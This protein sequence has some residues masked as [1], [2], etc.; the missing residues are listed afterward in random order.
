MLAPAWPG[1]GG[2][3]R[4]SCISN[5]LIHRKGCIRSVPEGTWDGEGGELRNIG[6]GAKAAA[7]L[8]GRID[9]VVLVKDSNGIALSGHVGALSHHLDSR[10]HQGLSVLLANLVLGGAGQGNIIL[11]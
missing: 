6:T 2:N 4:S 8:A 9:N 1:G 10:L 7:D 5:F 3:H 11:G